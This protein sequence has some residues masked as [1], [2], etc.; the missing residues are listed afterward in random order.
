MVGILRAVLQ[1]KWGSREQRGLSGSSGASQAEVGAGPVEGG[2]HG[3]HSWLPEMF[4]VKE[5]LSAR[6]G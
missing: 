3:H 2:H 6:G 5:V 4:V 1:T